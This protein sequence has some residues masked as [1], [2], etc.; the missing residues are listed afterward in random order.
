MSVSYSSVVTFRNPV[1]EP[2]T[3]V[4]YVF[5]GG[6]PG[7]SPGSTENPFKRFVE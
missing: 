7:I 6:V 3:A 5:I 2:F 1:A 4:V